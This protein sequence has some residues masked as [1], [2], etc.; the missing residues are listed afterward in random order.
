MLS[1]ESTLPTRQPRRP[2]KARVYLVEDHALVRRGV[3]WLIAGEDDLEVCGQ[4]EDAAPALAEMGELRPDVALVDLSLKSSCGL[5]LI[6]QLRTS[7]PQVRSCVFSVGNEAT[8][9][10]RALKAGALGYVMKH[11]SPPALL[12]AIRKVLRGQRHLSGPVLESMLEPLRP[13]GPTDPMSM[14]TD[15]E[16]N[17]ATL[18]GRGLTTS[19]IAYRLRMS[20][21]SVD[22]H[23]LQLRRKLN[24]NGGRELLLLCARW[25]AE[26]NAET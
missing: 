13:P 24:V 15:R 23:R 19:E 2:R 4:A 12:E 16:L 25:V 9:A 1:N 21:H 3:S 20:T 17:V 8:Y 11:E 6:K 7:L 18:I 26:N 22:T 5:D 10:A 14:L